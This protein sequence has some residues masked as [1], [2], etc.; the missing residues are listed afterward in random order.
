MTEP[1]KLEEDWTVNDV[2]DK[3]HLV[4]QQLVRRD[5][6]DEVDQQRPAQQ[7]I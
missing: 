3:H 4:T 5:T 1:T 6:I 2:V 7:L